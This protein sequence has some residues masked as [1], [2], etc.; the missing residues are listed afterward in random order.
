[1]SYLSTVDPALTSDI[2]QRKEFY[3]LKHWHNEPKKDQGNIIPRFLLNDAIE[4]SLNLRLSSYQVFVEN[5]INPNTPYQR[6][7]LKWSTGSGKTIGA[8]SIAMNFINCYRN[9]RDIGNVDIGSIFVIGFSERAFKNELLLHPEFGFLSQSERHKLDKLKRIASEGSK[10]DATKYQ[11]FVIKIKKRFGNRKGNGFFKFYGYKA[12]TNRIFIA[13]KDIDINTMNEYEIRKALAD[14]SLKYNEELLGQFKNSLI[15]CD[16]IH[17]VYNSLEKNNWGIAI[18]AVLDR[19]P[20]CRAI[21]ASATPFNN[22]PTEIV[23]LLNLLLPADQRV[24]KADFFIT[25]KKKS[26][27]KTEVI[28]KTEPK[29]IVDENEIIDILKP[30][31]LDKIAEL[32]RGR[33]SYLQ[34]INPQYY[35]SVSMAGESIPGIPYLKFIRCKM[36]PFQYNTYKNIQHE[37]LTQESQ[38]IVDFVLENPEN[39][40]G[41]YQTN[42]VKNIL[43][44]APVK[45][46]QKYGLDYIDGKITGTALERRNLEKYSTKYA[47]MLDDLHNIIKNRG[48]KTF[49]YHNIVHMS[50]V[51]FIEQVLLRNG[52]LD[53]F[54]SSNDSTICVVCGKRKDE[55]SPEQLLAKT[56]SAETDTHDL[57]TIQERTKPHEKETHESHIK[58]LKQYEKAS[59]GKHD[60]CIN[61]YTSKEKTGEKIVWKRPDDMLTIRK[62]KEN[63]YDEFDDYVKSHYYIEFVSC[64]ELV[65]NHDSHTMRDLSVLF[66]ELEKIP[67]VFQV[68]IKYPRLSEWLINM[69]FKLRN[70]TNKHVYMMWKP[71]TYG[72]SDNNQLSIDNIQLSIDNNQNNN[73]TGGKNRVKRHHISKHD[74]KQPHTFTPVRF[75]IAHSEID[76]STIEQSL[77]KFNGIDN[78]DGH[79]F[80]IL[81]GSRIIKESYNTKAIRNEFIMSKPDHIPML[82]QI[83]GRA[84]RK[85]SHKFLP[86]NQRHVTVSIYT[87]CL[88]VKEHGIYKLSY[89]EVKYKEKIKAF[90]IMQHIERIMHENAIDS[91][92]NYNLDRNN[93]MSTLTPGEPDPLGPLPYEPKILDD[94]GKPFKINKMSLNDLNLSTFDAY[95]QKR[96]VDIC[97]M[98]IKRLFIEYSPVFDHDTLYKKIKHAP[99]DMEI[100][101]E[102]ISHECYLLAISQLLWNNEPTIA[103]PFIDLTADS[104][105]YEA[106]T[107]TNN[108]AINHVINRL[109]DPSDKLITLPN[110]N[111]NIIVPIID[112]KTD[113][114]YYILFPINND[115]EPNIDIDTAFHVSKITAAKNIN[116]NNFMQTKRIDFDYDDKK[117]IFINK[118]ADIA[119]ENMENVVCEY[120]TLFHIKFAE[121]C[122]MY[123]F[124]VWTDPT[125][126]K[127]TYHEFYFKMLYYYDLL[128]LILWAY[129][130]KPKVFKQYSKYAIPVHAKDIKL[131]AMRLYEQREEERRKRE[132]RDQID[133]YLPADNSDL[134]TS[135][136][137][138]LLRTSLNRTSNVW[139]PQEFRNE[140]N[141]TIEKSLSLFAGRRKKV[142]HLQKISAQYLPIGHFLSKFPR[143]YM[144]DSQSFVEDPQ[145]KQSDESF[146]ENDIIVGFDERSETGVHIRFKLRQPYHQ[147]KKAKDSRTVQRGVVCKSKTKTQ[148]REIAKKL[149]VMLDIEEHYNVD[150]LCDLI[151]SKLIRLELKERINRTRI[152]WFYWHWEESE[153]L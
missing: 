94:R 151:R 97:K 47:T 87:S 66:D 71:K 146:K 95:Y 45:W 63:P 121:E 12:F 48:G 17:N 131:K 123:I 4:K 105:T 84:V 74:N 128:S 70:T 129:T 30:N 85:D 141:D 114:Q 78:T 11:D 153:K 21:F 126:E 144:P 101:K 2:V 136:I 100:N 80:L 92:A 132:G 127:S 150:N 29:K 139:I 3:W 115:G 5:F 35:P 32:C 6:L 75:V 122:I 52:F 107:S 49:I 147:I 103:E 22:S 65:M 102:L 149:D 59:K 120:G 33:I 24:S 64:H 98:I 83:R 68:S 37:T 10:Q 119:I 113:T 55:H 39:G 26:K 81:V 8:L 67:I 1:M 38:Y 111:D 143:L 118:Y 9:E 18:Q 130:C 148:L 117:K 19:E 73:I 42:Q 145:Y 60:D 152:K 27:K 36:S 46:K 96:E 40:L 28:K 23:D 57:D 44:H 43:A 93:K 51:L 41:I 20:T 142:K 72:G 106:N 13:N 53:E 124:R 109:F 79:K 69:G 104:D 125:L 112:H 62:L 56:G 90:Q 7:L 31:A 140:Y 16:E 34:D 50:G 61:L 99:Y 91:F 82:I 15:I 116:I 110:G 108:Q 88:P 137:I 138:N 134:A 86:P 135:G 77:D 54:S 14:G 89:E 58:A 25:Y 133:E 76:K